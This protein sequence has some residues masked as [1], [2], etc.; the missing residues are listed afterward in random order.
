M[1]KGQWCSWSDT[2]Y[3]NPAYDKLYEQQATLMDEAARKAMVD[4]MQQIVYDD[5][6]YT[7]LVNMNCIDAHR[8][9][10]GGLP[11]RAERLLQAFYT[12]RGQA[13]L[14]P[15]ETAGVPDAAQPSGRTMSRMRPD[16]VKRVLFALAITSWSRSRRTSCCSGPCPA[17]PSRACAAG[18]C[19][20]EFKQAA[21]ARARSG[22]AVAAQYGLYLRG[23]PTATSGSS[24]RAPYPPVRT[25]L[26]EPIKRTVP[27]ILLGTI[28]SIVI[29]MRHR[30]GG[31]LAAWARCSTGPPPGPRWPPTRCR[32]SGWRCCSCSTWP[33]GSGCPAPASG[34]PTWRW[35]SCWGSVSGWTLA[36][37]QVKHMILPALA[38]GIVF[39]GDYA[40][41][42][43][44]ALVETLGEDYVLTARA[45]GLPGRGGSSAGTRCATPC[46]RSPP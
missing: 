42:T 44:S 24:L 4:Q 23:S 41:I 9:R 43:R 35:R 21:G 18:T 17:T 46:C 20:V 38:I 40:I 31:R 34:T 15:G 37:D 3:D 22:P 1:T 25:T 10:L 36:V 29:G 8:Q 32:P 14:M 33:A 26:W 28:F 11:P 27:M 5:V 2:G 30:G 45:K 39:A 19:T 13:R 12:S 16:L 6:V 7:Q